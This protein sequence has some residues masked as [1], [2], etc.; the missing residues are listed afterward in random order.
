MEDIDMASNT[1][2]L[3]ASRTKRRVSRSITKRAEN[4]ME[5]KREQRV[6]LRI[7]P[8]AK[9]VIQQAADLLGMSLSTFLVSTGLK[10]ARSEIAELNEL[11]LSDRDRDLFLKT[12]DSPPAPTS[13]LR[14][15]MARFRTQGR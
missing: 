4:R 8:D 2:R 10:A 7:Q 6:D 13:A 11:R 15:A 3:T 9:E 1:A 14:D 5:K 12:L